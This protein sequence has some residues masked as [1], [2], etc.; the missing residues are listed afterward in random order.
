MPSI[1]WCFLFPISKVHE[2]VDASSQLVLC[3]PSKV[4]NQHI[5]LIDGL[6]RAHATLGRKALHFYAEASLYEHLTPTAREEVMLHPIPVMDPERR[7]LVRKSLLE[8]WV[9][10]RRIAA[11]KRD[12]VLLVTCL[13]PSSLILVEAFKRFFPKARVVVMLHGEIEGAFDRRRQSPHSFGFYVLRWLRLRSAAST[14]EIAVIDEFIARQL[15]IR[16]PGKFDPTK[17]HVLPFPLLARDG[18]RLLKEDSFRV[19]FIGFDTPNKGFRHFAM[20]AECLKD[21]ESITIGGGKLHDLRSGEVRPISGTDAYLEAIE[22]CDVAVFPYVDGYSCS[23]SAAAMDALSAGLHM[24]A[25]DRGCFVALADAL[26]PDAVTIEPDPALFS[27]WLS[28]AKW[29]G[30]VRATRQDRLTRVRTSRY[31]CEGVSVGLRSLIAGRGFTPF[32]EP[33][34]WAAT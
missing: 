20:L 1:D 8:V 24:L 29:R 26:G 21:V 15:L 22:Q 23:L 27:A 6:V 12:Q 17:L 28:D 18:V 34:L 11:V 14:L 5:T 30:R 2:K 3:E 16:F 7:R 31:T 10:C 19:C 9:T 13:L 4:R 33:V 25:T 32:G